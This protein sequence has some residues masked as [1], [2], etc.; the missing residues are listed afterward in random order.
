MAFDQV[1]QFPKELLGTNRAGQPGSV[2]IIGAG[3]AGLSA[4]YELER[5]GHRVA[6]FEDSTRPGGRI[7]THRFADGTHAELGAMRIPANHG[8]TMH[9]IEQFN[10][11]VRRFVNYNPKAYYYIR[12]V[13]TRLGDPRP[14]FSAF[15]LQPVEQSDPLRQYENLMKEL[16]TSL[17][18]K[19]RLEIFAPKLTSE[20][21]RQYAS[22]S[23]WQFLRERLSPEAFELIGHST[24]MIQY[25]RASLLEVFVDYFGLF[26][27]DQYELEGG[28]ESLVRAFVERLQAPI[29]YNARVSGIQLTEDGVIV[30]YSR[31]GHKQSETFDYVICTVPAPAL[32]RIEFDPPLPVR[33]RQ[34]IGG[35]TY[36]SSAKT[37]V[38]TTARPWE[39]KDGI[40]GGGSFTDLPIQQIWYP[41]DNAR[42]VDQATY[43]AF[44]GDS[45]SPYSE[46]P[47]NWIAQSEERSHAPGTLTASYL[48]ESN[49]RRFLSLPEQDQTDIVLGHA[50]KLHPGLDRYV[51][52]IVH[53]SWDRQSNP[54]G[55]AFAYFAP[56][57][58]ERYQEWLGLPFPAEQ[59]SVFFAG[60]HLAV[61]H[62]WI[63]GAIQTA[64]QAVLQI[65][66]L[67]SAKRRA[68]AIS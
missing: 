47:L 22:V 17:T 10:L 37:I 24:G 50:G 59:P 16:M 30:H 65:E 13:K 21:L 46:A 14:L 53:W 23:F 51:D 35:I 55:G 43:A 44:T 7:R 62:A 12:D 45:G 42:P 15:Q 67:S 63:Q 4:A 60:E 48:W 25:E 41:S 11:P 27:V 1:F 57:E 28:M 56:G 34:A 5:L 20:K 8:C 3:A 2:G 31:L 40:F 39:F 64:L 54:G 33:Q 52:E 36:A 26:R 9:Y 18:P 19:E 32:T 38:H 68:A 49:A 66:R 6:I 61:A 58:H 29:H